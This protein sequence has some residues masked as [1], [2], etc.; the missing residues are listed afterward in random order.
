M[1]GTLDSRTPPPLPADQLIDNFNQRFLS[2]QDL[3]TAQASGRPLIDRAGVLQQLQQNRLK[4]GLTKV[5]QAARVDDFTHEYTATLLCLFGLP[6]WCP[7]LRQSHNA[8]Y[9]VAHERICLD[10]FRQACIAGAYNPFG[11]TKS[12]ITD[13]PLLVKLYQHR[14]FHDYFK[15]VKQEEKKPGSLAE[16]VSRH[17]AII[18]RKKV[19]LTFLFQQ[20]PTNIKIQLA[21]DRAEWCIEQKYPQRYVD[22]AGNPAATSDDEYNPITRQYEIKLKPG[23]NKKITFFFRYADY[24]RRRLYELKNQKPSKERVR[25]VPDHQQESKLFGIP[26]NV[27]VDYYTPEFFNGLPRIIRNRIIGNSPRVAFAEGAHWDISDTQRAEPRGPETLQDSK[28]MH[29]FGPQ[30][31]APYDLPGDSDDE[32]PDHGPWHS[33]EEGEGDWIDP[34]E[35]RSA[36]EAHS[37]YSMEDENDVEFREMQQEFSFGEPMD[38]RSQPSGSARWA[39]QAGSQHET[40][41]TIV[42]STVVEPMD[43]RSQ[44]SRSTRRSQS[45]RRSGQA[46]LRRETP[47]TIVPYSVEEDV[48][49]L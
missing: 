41:Q 1:F 40:A 24:H 45:T 20:V 49:E 27:P 34:N 8:V 39:G 2:N 30:L 44:P 35:P 38:T 46:R 48:E 10:S 15:R 22:I 12:F 29:K 33:S 18:A 37:D 16:G 23:R 43:A 3:D 32:D 26:I 6:R 21:D 47:Q 9:N 36:D 28:F 4:G 11:I 7:D 19:R 5:S 31:L 17:A 14:V 25:V 42:P 13:L